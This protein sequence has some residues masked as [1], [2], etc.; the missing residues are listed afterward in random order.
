MDSSL[1]RMQEGAADTRSDRC[2]VIEQPFRGDVH[3]ARGWN[4]PMPPGDAF[5]QF[6]FADEKEWGSENLSSN[7]DSSL[8]LDSQCLV[9]TLQ[10]L[11]LHLRLNV[12]ADLVQE[13]LPQELPQS[14][15]KTITNLPQNPSIQKSAPSTAISTQEADHLPKG[16][17]TQEVPVSGLDKELDFLLSLE[18]PVKD[19]MAESPVHITEHDEQVACDIP[20]TASVTEVPLPAEEKQTTVTSEDLEDWLDSMIA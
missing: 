2:C 13:E 15:L 10:E 1:G 8:Y 12:E 20:A 11:P 19:T 18:T 3:T 4:S 14:T 17:P 7:Q 6:R 5:T 16:K 9:R